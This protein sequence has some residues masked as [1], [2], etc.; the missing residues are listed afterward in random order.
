[1]PMNNPKFDRERHCRFPRTPSFAEV[2]E[3]SVNAGVGRAEISQ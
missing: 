2:R 3:H 1:M